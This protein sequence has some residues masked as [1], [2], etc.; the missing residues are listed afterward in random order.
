MDLP[1]N[2]I[3]G[4]FPSSAPGVPGDVQAPAWQRG[5]R[6]ARQSLVLDAIRRRAGEQ[7]LDP[8]GVAK[9]LG[10]SVR[11]LHQL[12]ESTGRTFSQ[13]LIEQRLERAR[14]ELCKPDCGLKIADIAFACGFSDISH[15][16]RR[17]R[18]AFGDTP[19]GV[20]VRAAR[21]STAQESGTCAI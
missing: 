21:A 2:V 12:L 15:F 9:H 6:T 11:Y 19:Y 20:R 1:T 3:Q 10:M 5:V 18:H 14:A 13:H 16:N 17:F 7:G 8:A 4:N